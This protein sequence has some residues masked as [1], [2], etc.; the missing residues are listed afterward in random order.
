[1]FM[2]PCPCMSMRVHVHT[3]TE[4]GYRDAPGVDKPLA[5]VFVKASCAEIFDTSMHHCLFVAHRWVI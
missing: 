4:P 1:M 2:H 3:Q 5:I